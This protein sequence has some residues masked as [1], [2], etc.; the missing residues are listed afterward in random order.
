MRKTL[1]A[2]MAVLAGVLLGSSGCSDSDPMDPGGSRGTDPRGAFVF[3]QSSDNISAVD[4][5]TG[6]VTSN[7]GGLAIGP[8][9]NRARIRGGKA[10]VV[11]S[12][13][14]PDSSGASLQVI[15]LSTYTVENTIPFP[16]GENPWD[17][18]FV[19]GT[20]AYV[21]TLY[22]NHVTVLDLTR[23]GAEAITG[24]ISLPLF[25]GSDGY[26]PAGPESILVLDGFA[27]TANT[28]LDTRSY[29]YLPGSVSVIS[30][31]TDAVVDLIHTT[32]VN[33]QD[34]AVDAQGRINV[35]C[36]G[37]YYSSFG[38][39]DVIDPA[40]RA[41]VASLPLG[42]SPGNIT[43]AGDYA[44][45]GAGDTD[46]CDL[47][48]VATDTHTVVYDQASPWKL[49]DSSGWCT[50]GKIDA[51]RGPSGLRA[52]VPAGVWGA[53]ARLYEL[54]LD[55]VTPAVAQTYV[56]NPGANLPVAVGVLH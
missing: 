13:A 31:A 21:T 18:A 3:N 47:Y 55:A 4:L 30:T 43:V 27:Y 40:A 20:K 33:P 52:F 37:D 6:A 10:Y 16:D 45:V 35:I 19:S 39:L 53:E 9:A 2:G 41:V 22:G 48:M 34:L 8:L 54:R 28:A 17:M 5:A 12:G 44:L 42:G 51:A 1:F 25:I 23:S 15:D 32:Q 50:V 26:V 29:T 49:M 14:F 11:N 24:T 56:L 38:V 7:V 46:S 36:T